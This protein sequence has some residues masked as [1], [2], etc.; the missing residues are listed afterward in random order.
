MIESTIEQMLGSYDWEEAFK[1]AEG[2]WSRSI[3]ELIC[4]GAA[5]ALMLAAGLL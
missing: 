4:D 3:G 1:Y 5:I 2:F